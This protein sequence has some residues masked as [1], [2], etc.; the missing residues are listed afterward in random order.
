MCSPSP[1]LVHGMLGMAWVESSRR[2]LPIQR[3]PAWQWL[4]SSCRRIALNHGDLRPEI[5]D[6]TRRGGAQ[7]L[8]GD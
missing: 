7:P 4:R 3:W 5:R 2:A 6:R 8:N 1:S